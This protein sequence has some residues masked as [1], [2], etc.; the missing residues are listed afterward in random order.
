MQFVIFNLVFD[1]SIQIFPNFQYSNF[2]FAKVVQPKIME[3]TDVT[4]I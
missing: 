3:S 1:I 2:N 4:C